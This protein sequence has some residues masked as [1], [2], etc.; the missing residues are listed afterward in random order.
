MKQMTLKLLLLYVS[1]GF[2][3]AQGDAFYKE[4][5]LFSTAPS[6]TKSV[7]SIDRFGPVGIGIELHQPAFVM[8]VK[9]VE[10]GSPAAATGK[11]KTGQVIESIN[12]QTLKDI[13]PRIQLGGIIEAAEASDGII[14]FAIKG[15]AEPVV[16]KIPVLGAYSKSWPLNCPKSARIVRDFA[17]YLAKPDSDKGFG[18]IGMLFLL[19][20][21]EERDIAPVRDWVHGMIGKEPSKYA[22]ILGYGGIPLCEYYLRTGDKEALPVIQAWVEAAADG[23]Y[24]DGWAGRGG[25]TKVSYGMGH[26]NAGGT[27][28]VTFLLLAKE[29][30]ADVDESLLHRTLV[31]FFRFAGRGL[32]PYGDDRPENSF[33]DNGKNGNLAFA[34]AAAAS[35]TPEGEKSIYARARDTAAM[36]S[37]YTTTY[38]LHGHTGGGIGE[39]WRSMA[40]GLLNEK[41]PNQYRE[42]M[43]NRKWHYEL[44]RRFDGSFGI[45]GGAGYDKTQWGAGYALTYTIPRKTLCITGAVS[46]F[47]KSFKLPERPWGTAADDEFQSL[48]A[49][50]D[51]NGKREDL[52]HE[53]LAKDSGKPLIERINAMGDDVSDDVLRQYVRHQDYLIRRLAANQAMG[54]NFSYMFKNPGA[55]VRPALIGEFCKSPDPRV[56]NAGLRA[57]AENFDFSAEWAPALF[58]IAVER[59]KDPEESWWIKD[60]ALTIVGRGTPDMIAP[61]V[62]LLVSYLKHQEQ[63]LQNGALSALAP[64]VADE[65]C[66]GE[67]LPAI[68]EMARNC[69]RYSTTGGPMRAIREQL[70]TA[71]PEVSELAIK[72]LGEAYGHYAGVRIWE[73]GQNVSSVYDAH[74][75]VMADVLAGVPGGYD[76]LYEIA[77]NRY[78]NEALPHSTVFLSGDP[79]MFGPKL[80]EA[81]TPI[82]TEKLIPEFVGKNRRRLQALGAAEVQSERAGG[83][84]DSVDQLAGL[85][86]RAGRDEFGWNM[87]LD[88]RNADWSYHSFDPIPTEQVPWDKVISRYREVT[89]PSGMDEW[90][91]P[92]FDPAKA[93]W[94]TAKSPF[95]QYNGKLPDRPFMKCD[96]TCV[97]PGCYAAT[98][99]NTYWDK[100][101]LLMRGNFKI[102]PIMEGHRYRI[103]VNDGEHPGAGGGYIIY[104]NGK[105]L[106]EAKSCSGRGSIGQPKGAFITKDFLGDL[107]AGEVTIAVKTFLRFNDKFLAGPTE[108]IPQGHISLH[109]EEM[110]LPPMGDDLVRKSATVVP[111]MTSAWQAQLDPESDEQDP[112]NGKL[113]WDGKFIPN[114]AVI[115]SWEVIAEVPEIV[116]FN[117]EK[118]GKARK[119]PFSSITFSDGGETSESIWIWSGKQLFDLASYQALQIEARKIGDGEY[120]FVEAGG[121]STRNKPGW[122]SLY[123]VLQRK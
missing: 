115:G 22:W 81:L 40:M 7:S 37:F 8:K 27:A 90:H 73:G 82:I 55:R 116:A 98:K 87:F 112:E 13:D 57:V 77:K 92:G 123:Y 95:G 69:Q 108:R 60:A 28:V 26:L 79:H 72:S 63:W 47:A 19:S 64:V 83:S 5:P 105:P 4:P 15:E 11:L 88:L 80:K 59:L 53:T 111:M 54:M 18:D 42:F 62:D 35:L 99:V 61:H 38:M 29:C 109:L 32:N 96:D 114:P 50:A 104:I 21:G 36:T 52:T 12:G 71:S 113:R 46:K 33:V 9:N 30:G 49:V 118:P 70:Q 2:G 78:P 20:T 93:G 56:R 110:L 1:A 45:L 39:I 3:I 89:M 91:A 48:E 34:M 97:G 17:D 100:E 16:V 103:R 24:L 23:E 106:I 10:E 41:R 44:S 102:P 75:E 58:A 31:H 74:L 84:N 65:R 101:V 120:L 25:V 85:Y 6:A 117:P 66:Y 94:K 67:A 122:K 68:G 86:S 43:D 14:S 121:F 51:E 119:P 107:R 76:V